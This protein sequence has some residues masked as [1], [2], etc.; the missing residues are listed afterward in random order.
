MD[1]FQTRILEI[2]RNEK[3]D[4]HISDVAKKLGVDRHTASKHLDELKKI[5]L[6]KLRN[7][8]KSKLY[9][10]HDKHSSSELKTSIQTNKH[11][12]LWQN[13][14]ESNKTHSNKCYEAFLGKNEKCSNCPVE[15]TFITGDEYESELLIE[16]KRAIIKTKPIKNSKNDTVA[17]M[18]TM[19]WK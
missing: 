11:T 15:K 18:E 5:K 7:V 13:K 8:G 19:K 12:I 1:I 10:I 6:I 2:L 9:S 16:N 4:L 17:V 14:K 3:N